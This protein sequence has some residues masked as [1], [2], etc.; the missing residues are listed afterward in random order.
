MMKKLLI[1][2]GVLVAVIAVLG[3]IAPTE[4]KIEK[5]ILIEKPKDF[6][7]A[8]LKLLKN[9][10][11]WSPWSKLDPNMSHEYRGTDGSIGFVSAWAGNDKVGVGEQELKKIIEGERLEYELRFKEPFEDTSLIYLVTESV[12]PTQTRVKWGMEGTNK[13]PRNIFCLV[14]NLKKMLGDQLNEGL[15][16]LKKNLEK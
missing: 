8:E 10:D 7:F 13:F 12:S 2:V 15:V 11:S 14:M 16:S 1:V 9:H 5:E 4:M 3:M 6:V